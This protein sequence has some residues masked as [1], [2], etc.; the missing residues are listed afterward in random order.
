MANTLVLNLPA[1]VRYRLTLDFKI[2]YLIGLS[3]IP[4]LIF[5]FIQISSMA[6]EGYQVRNYQH[7]INEL[8]TENKVLEVNLSQINSLA[9][10]DNRIQ[11]MGFQKVGEIS[12][13]QLLENSVV[14]K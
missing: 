2:F 3:I 10:I 8:S 12:Y 7:S 14:A 13:I 4:L 11:E 1:P 5:Y 6:S 9:G